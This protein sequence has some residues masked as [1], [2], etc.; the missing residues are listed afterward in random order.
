[1]FEE[2]LKEFPNFTRVEKNLPWMPSSTF[3]SPMKLQFA[4]Q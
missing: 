3:R 1:L 4:I 2:F